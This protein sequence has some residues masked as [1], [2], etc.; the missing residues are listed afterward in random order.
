MLLSSFDQ[1]GAVDF[2]FGDRAVSSFLTVSRR[3]CAAR[4]PS[5]GAPALRSQARCAHPAGSPAATTKAAP[6]LV[7]NRLT[8]FSSRCAT[9]ARC[10]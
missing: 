6:E 2:G 3:G 8:P 10:R 7:R 5:G 9:V 1:A 4:P